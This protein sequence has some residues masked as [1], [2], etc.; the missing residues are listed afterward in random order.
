MTD[1]HDINELDVDAEQQRLDALGEA[2]EGTREK[3]ADDLEPG[4]RGRTFTDEGVARQVEETGD[5]DHPTGD[6]TGE[7]A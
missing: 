4:G 3:A 6:G 5:T 2:I 1:A 7:D